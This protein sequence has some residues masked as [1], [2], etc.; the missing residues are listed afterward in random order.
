MRR[1]TR[2]AAN[3]SPTP[4]RVR[5][6]HAFHLAPHDDFTS[7]R[8]LFAELLHDVFDLSGYRT[9]I[10]ILHVRVNVKHGLDIAVVGD[11]R[12]NAVTHRGDVAQQLRP[13]SGSHRDGSV[14]HCR[15]RIQPVLRSLGGNR[16]SN[17][18]PRI[19]PEVRL[20]LSTRRQRTNRLFE[21]SSWV[22]PNC[23]A[24]VR[25]TSR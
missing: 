18:H 4:S 15:D 21:T 19:E 5:L 10:A 9:E 16:V 12:Y 17:A 14:L 8:E 25:S 1:Y 13:P 23:A 24:R 7:R 3:A 20:N 6:L 22:R 2:T 11:H